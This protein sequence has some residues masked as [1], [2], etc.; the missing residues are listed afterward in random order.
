MNIYNH[1]SSGKYHVT[2]GEDYL[3]HQYINEK[4]LIAAVMD[5]C[6]SGKESFFASAAYGKSLRKSCRMLPNMKEIIS[7]FDL[8]SMEK[9]AIGTFILQ[10]LYT[11][12][13]KLKKLF[14]LN[15]E[16]ILSTLTLMVFDLNNNSAWVNMSG[17]GIIYCNGELHEIDQKNMPDYLGY[18][19][20]KPFEVWYQDHTECKE[21]SNITDISISTDGI[22]KLVQKTPGEGEEIDPID[23][24]LGQKPNI[25]SEKFLD[26]AYQYL[27]KSIGYIP[28]DDMGIIRL[29]P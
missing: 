6:S 27:T 25:Y 14:F 5:G 20:D 12:I 17:D 7:V 10:Q 18:H 26:E 15:I 29:I 9:E 16:E 1:L 3:Y 24:F 11:D 22:N 19:L 4:Y 13:K 21:Y 2:N 23:Y 8:L 28:Y